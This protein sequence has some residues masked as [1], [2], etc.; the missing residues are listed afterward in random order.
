LENDNGKP[1]LSVPEGDAVTF[2]TEMIAAEVECIRAGH[3][4]IWV[5]CPIPGLDEPAG[6][7]AEEAA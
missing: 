3:P 7:A 6:P 5:D 1:F 4:V 2:D